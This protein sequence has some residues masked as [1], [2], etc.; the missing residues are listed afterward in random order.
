MKTAPMTASYS[1]PTTTEAVVEEA[2]VEVVDAEVE[3]AE[4]DEVEETCAGIKTS[5]K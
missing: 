1:I 5:L 3:E 4:E 2:K